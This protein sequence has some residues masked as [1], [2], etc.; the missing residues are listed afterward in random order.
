[1][2][3]DLHQLQAV[4][5]DRVRGVAYGHSTGFYL[6]GRPGSGKTHVV[7][8][9]LEGTDKP[10]V[11]HDGHLTPLGLFELLCQQRDRVVVLDDV[12]SI[13]SQP[14]ALQIL[15]AALG[16]QPGAAGGRVVSYR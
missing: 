14:V 8:R 13:F 9:T 16:R 11:Y 4:V 7:R 2:P 6:A 1:M 15:L 5:R 3:E 10:Y 12:S